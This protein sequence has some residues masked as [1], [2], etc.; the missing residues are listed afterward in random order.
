M[1]SSLVDDPEHWRSRAEEARSIAEELSDP[2]A[3]RM[4]LRIVS[5]YERLAERAELRATK[6]SPASWHSGVFRR[7]LLARPPWQPRA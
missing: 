6:Q 2:E 1:P 4:M 7:Q 5:D 3:K